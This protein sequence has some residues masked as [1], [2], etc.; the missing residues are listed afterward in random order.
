MTFAIRG[1][2]RASVSFTAPDGHHRRMVVSPPWSRTFTVNDG[3][4]VDVNAHGTGSGELTC[5][6]SVDGELVKSA[7]SSGG[8]STVDCGDSLGF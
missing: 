5:T 3:Q 1:N 8:S 2:G 4:K 7:T 6:L